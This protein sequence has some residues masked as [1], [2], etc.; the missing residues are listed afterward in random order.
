MKQI[1]QQNLNHFIGTWDTEGIILETNNAAAIEIKGTDTY[2][3]ILNGCFILHEANVMVG[4]SNILT[5]E[6]I[7]Y[8]ILNQHYTMQYFNNQGQS[9]FMKAKIKNNIW[10][11]TGSNL[12]FNGAFNRKNK[13]FSG[14]WKQLSSNN[15]WRDFIHIKLTRR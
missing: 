9:G 10:S 14:I 7:G 6:I 8:D 2:C 4:N 3:W 15:I 1:T 12:K 5:H 11:F 13:E